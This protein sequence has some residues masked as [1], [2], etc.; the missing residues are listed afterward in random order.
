MEIKAI[1]QQQI[2]IQSEQSTF[3]YFDRNV[4]KELF[5]FNYL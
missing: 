5:N 4:L 3:I 1:N 2:F